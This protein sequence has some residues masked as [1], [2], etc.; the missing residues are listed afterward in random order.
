MNILD[1]PLSL[2][3]EVCGQMAAVAMV[4]SKSGEQI[5]L[6]R[7]DGTLYIDLNC[8]NCGPVQQEIDI[9]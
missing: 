3:C 4:A 6:V 7:I 8:P 1:I 2:Q 9:S 5:V